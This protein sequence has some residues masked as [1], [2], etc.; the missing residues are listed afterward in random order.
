M[1][2]AVGGRLFMYDIYFSGKPQWR[3]EGRLLP[4]QKLS[5][6][7]SAMQ[8]STLRLRSV[9]WER[10]LMFVAIALGLGLVLVF[11][12]A[13]KAAAQ[14][15]AAGDPPLTFGNNFFV[16]GDYVVAGAQG[17]ATNFDFNNGLAI[18]RITVP[19][20]NP[21]IKPSIITGTNSVPTEAKIFAAILYW[22]TVEKIGVMAG[23]PGSGQNGFFRPLI[24]V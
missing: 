9:P 7:R 3:T 17:M 16:T 13:R 23:Q 19:D 1:Q 12:F 22:Q 20:P 24:G 21:G 8:T 18:G 14:C 4:S 2:I 6:E 10:R 5:R 15:A 11:G